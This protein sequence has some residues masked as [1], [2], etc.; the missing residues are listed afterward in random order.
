M[1]GHSQQNCTGELVSADKE[2]PLCL[3]RMQIRPAGT[4]SAVAVVSNLPIPE[5]DINKL[6]QVQHS[7]TQS[8]RPHATSTSKG[9]H[10]NP[11]YKP[12]SPWTDKIVL[13]SPLNMSLCYTAFTLHSRRTEDRGAR[14][15][16]AHL[17]ASLTLDSTSTTPSWCPEPE[18]NYSSAPRHQRF[19]R[20]PPPNRC[21]W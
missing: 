4:R 3:Q 6:E 17:Q 2:V 16:P 9:V 1:C 8:A 13:F 21:R 14:R 5:D 11:S 12:A 10:L 18:N 15:R 19:Q 7:T 20:R